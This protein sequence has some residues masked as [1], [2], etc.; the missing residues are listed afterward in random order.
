M[1]SS[2]D[3]SEIIA[4]IINSLLMQTPIMLVC[5]AGAIATLIFRR[6]LRAGIVPAF[7]GFVMLLVLSITTTVLWAILPQKIHEMGYDMNDETTGI[8]FTSIGIIQS[9]L[10]ALAILLLGLGIFLGRARPAPDFL[11]SS[12]S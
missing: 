6:N 7:S 5:L 11:D 10:W 2:P 9:C 12:A 4:Q 8:I 3:T 1:G